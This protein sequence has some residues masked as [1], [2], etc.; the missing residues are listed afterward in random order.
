MLDAHEMMMVKAEN[1]RREEEY[2]ASLR[3]RD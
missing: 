2:Q 3:E 1:Q